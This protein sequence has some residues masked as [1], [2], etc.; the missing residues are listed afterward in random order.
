MNERDERQSIVLAWVRR[1]FG[2]KLLNVEERA[3]RVL[4]E[5]MELAQASGVAER[6]SYALL[7][8]VYSKPAGKAHQELGGLGV[9]LLAYSAVVGTSADEAE[10]I[11]VERVTS[12]PMDHFRIRQTLKANAGV[13]DLPTK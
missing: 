13:A 6:R 12:L 1:T 8:H 5:A 7:Q 11:E 2:E 9:T 4:E 10:R 3:L